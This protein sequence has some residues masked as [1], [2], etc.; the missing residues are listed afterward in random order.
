MLNGQTSWQSNKSLYPKANS[1]AKYMGSVKLASKSPVW[2]DQYNATC[3]FLK[4]NLSCVRI[5]VLLKLGEITPH[6]RVTA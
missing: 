6:K 2:V 5:N 1:T 3:T 4:L